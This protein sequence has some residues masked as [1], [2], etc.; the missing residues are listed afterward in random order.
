MYLSRRIRVCVQPALRQP[1]AAQSPERGFPGAQAPA[2][3]PRRLQSACPYFVRK[4][5][6]LQER[7][8]PRYR[9]AW[10]SAKSLSLLYIW[11]RPRWVSATKRRPFRGV[12]G[13]PVGSAKPPFRFKAFDPAPGL[14]HVL[15]GVHRLLMPLGQLLGVAYEA[16]YELSLGSV[17]LDPAVGPV[18]HV[19]VTIG[20]HRHVRRAVQLPSAG[21]V[22][23]EGSHPLPVRCELLGRWFL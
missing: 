10:A 19:H 7:P 1:T 11:R 14:D 17:N 15:V 9:L 23:A 8:P 3:L 20:V 13:H 16:G 2:R 22:A 21:A 4:G 5:A 6:H 12:K 18:T